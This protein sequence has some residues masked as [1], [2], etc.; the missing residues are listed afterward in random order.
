MADVGVASLLTW[1]FLFDC[2]SND[3][4][5]DRVLVHG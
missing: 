5:F 3:A 4:Q 1:T 2:R